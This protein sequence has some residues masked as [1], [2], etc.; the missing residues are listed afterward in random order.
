MRKSILDKK[1]WQFMGLAAALKL[2]IV[3]ALLVWN[4]AE[5][6]PGQNDSLKD[7][8]EKVETEYRNLL[9]GI[10]EIKEKNAELREQ[11]KK[12][13]DPVITCSGFCSYDAAGNRNH[14][15]MHSTGKD[16]ADQLSKLVDE[17]EKRS[18]YAEFLDECEKRSNYAEFRA[19]GSALPS[20]VTA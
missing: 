20:V 18:N 2:V 10:T 19:G 9:S 17:C 14:K 15:M 16:A 7:R 11:L 13:H 8:I 6:G 3:G 5:A 1:Q 4:G 12:P